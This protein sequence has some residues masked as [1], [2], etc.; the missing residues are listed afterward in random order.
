[1]EFIDIKLPRFHADKLIMFWLMSES[2]QFRFGNEIE[3]YHGSNRAVQIRDVSYHM[4]VDS[5]HASDCSRFQIQDLL[6]RSICSAKSS[7]VSRY[8]R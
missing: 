4:Y 2:L 7:I 6:S 8:F 1:M 5:M 3:I